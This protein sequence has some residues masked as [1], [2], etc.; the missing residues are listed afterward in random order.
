MPRFHHPPSLEDIVEMAEQAFAAIPKE[1]RDLVRGAAIVV[2]EVAD[3][4][5]AA[6]QQ[7][8]ERVAE[9]GRAVARRDGMRAH[10]VSLLAGCRRAMAS[11]RLTPQG[12]AGCP[13][14]GG[15][16]SRSSRSMSSSEKPK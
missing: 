3:E 6:E 7:R 14:A 1:L 5:T 2:E 13:C 4:E 12:R 8:G 16:P 11:L 15:Y 9:P 10:G